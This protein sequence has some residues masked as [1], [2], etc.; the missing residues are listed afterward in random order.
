MQRKHPAIFFGFSQIPRSVSRSAGW[1]A[2]TGSMAL[3]VSKP[4]TAAAPHDHDRATVNRVL[5][6]WYTV[7]N[8]YVT[9]V[10]DQ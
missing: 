8:S 1:R 2:P 5:L 9:V 6:V 3:G 4:T 7:A 10:H